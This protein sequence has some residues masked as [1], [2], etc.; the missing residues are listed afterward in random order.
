MYNLRVFGQARWSVR[1]DGDDRDGRARGGCL[2][3]LAVFLKQNPSTVLDTNARKRTPK[4]REGASLPR[5]CKH[6]HG[7]VWWAVDAPIEERTP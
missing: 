5:I 3:Y 7:F 4:D 1:G 6:D 2:L